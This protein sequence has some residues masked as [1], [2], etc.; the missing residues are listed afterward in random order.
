MAPLSRDDALRMIH[1]IKAAPV[2][3]GVRGRRRGDIEALAELLVKLSR[4]AI[5]HAGQFRAFDL[6]PIIVKAAGE[7]AVAVDIAV[8]LDG[9]IAETQR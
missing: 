7:G 4:F 9:T 1:R 2:L 6:N 5:A 3:L 8:D